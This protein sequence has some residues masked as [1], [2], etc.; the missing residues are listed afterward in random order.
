MTTVMVRVLVAV[1]QLTAKHQAI[2]N[3]KALLKEA[4]LR[5]YRDPRA[6]L[7]LVA[8]VDDLPDSTIVNAG[9]ADLRSA[10]MATARANLCFQ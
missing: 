8:L 2:R 1:A 6:S 4:E 5:L 3:A 10:I 7:A 9:L